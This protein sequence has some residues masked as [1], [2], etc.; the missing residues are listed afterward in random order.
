M[1]VMM[2]KL[3]QSLLEKQ[4][5]KRKAT[6]TAVTDAII[7]LE[8]QGYNT[9]IKDIMFVTGLSRSVFSKPHIRR[10]LIEFGIVNPKEHSCI[11]KNNIKPR[12]YEAML[13][14]KDGYIDRLLFQNERLCQEIEALRGEIHIMMYRTSIEDSYDF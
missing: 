9:R 7:E 2:K 12:N 14:E 10:V 5:L 3:P 4:E 6:V 11:H 8:S 1:I 13:A